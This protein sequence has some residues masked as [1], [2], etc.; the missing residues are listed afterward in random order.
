MNATRLASDNVEALRPTR[1][2]ARHRTSEAVAAVYQRLA[3]FYDIVYGAGLAH[4]RRVAMHRLAP[5]D[6]ERI[7]EIGVGTGLSACAYPAGCR[8]VAVD[9][10]PAMLTRARTRLRRRHIANVSLCQMD[11]GCLAF[12]DAH[13]D[14]IYAPYILNVVPDPLRVVGEMR[15]VCGRGGRLVLLNHFAPRAAGSPSS[16]LT[17][18]LAARICGI[19]WHLDLAAFLQAAGLTSSS[20]D[21]ANL[22]VSSVV[23][24]DKPSD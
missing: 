17:W 21:E 3:P 4:G 11:A 2:D 19:N 18:F 12:P 5:R 10:S 13:F 9:L 24:C 20:V 1:N 7:L 23:V 16:R 6:G 8:V 15:R 14:A 22:G